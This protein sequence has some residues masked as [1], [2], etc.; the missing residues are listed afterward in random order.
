MKVDKEDVPELIQ[1]LQY[2]YHSTTVQATTFDGRDWLFCINQLCNSVG[3]M[4]SQPN[5]M[6]WLEIEN[7]ANKLII[8]NWKHCNDKAPINEVV[9]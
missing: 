7:S 2:N 9:H 1:R 6:Q 8:K 3:L 4:Q 5:K